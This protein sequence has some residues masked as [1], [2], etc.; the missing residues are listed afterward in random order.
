MVM[1]P[2]R[3]FSRELHEAAEEKEE[4]FSRE[5]EELDEAYK[6]GFRSL[7]DHSDAPA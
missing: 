3:E 6:T 2:G 5:L 4:A 7:R 1:P